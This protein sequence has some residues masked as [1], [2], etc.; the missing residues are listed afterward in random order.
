MPA[1]PPFKKNEVRDLYARGTWAYAL[2]RPA[3]EHAQYAEAIERAQYGKRRFNPWWIRNFGDVEATLAGCW[4]DEKAGRDVV[5]FCAIL[6][7]FE[8]DFAGKPFALSDWQTYDIV[9]PVFGW[10]QVNGTR[11]F[12]RVHN[13][14]PKKNGKTSLAAALIL[15]FLIGDNEP[16]AEIFTAAVDR[17]QSGKMFRSVVQM[18]R[19]SPAILK[20]VDI[21]ESRYRVVCQSTA[22]FYEALSGEVIDM[23]GANIYA[24]LKDEAHVWP[25]DAMHEVTK[26]GGA[27]RKQP[28]D[29]LIST[30]GKFD[31]TSYGYN[32]YDF[33][34]KYLNAIGGA[35]KINEFFGYICGLTKDE[36]DF[37]REPAMCV[38]ANPNIDISI[39]LEADQKMCDEAMVKQREIPG[40]KRYRRNI[41]VNALDAWIPQDKW[42]ARREDYTWDDLKDL[43][44]YAGLDL[45]LSDD[46]TALDLCFPPQGELDTYRFWS[47]YWC[48]EGVIEKRDE[49]YNGWYSM[50]AKDGY[51]LTTPGETIKQEFVHEK[52]REVREAVALR[53]IGYDRA[54][55]AKLAQDLETDG[56]DVGAFGQGFPAMNEPTKLLYD[57]VMDGRMQHPGHPI[58]DWHVSNALAIRDGGDR[59]RIVKNWGAG[60]G[61]AKVR[62]KVD[63]VIAR[64]QS[65]GT[66]QLDPIGVFDAAELIR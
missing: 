22:S 61:K 60:P 38:K 64:I 10:K 9:I 56:F 49:Q 31:P 5:D 14:V 15:Y 65:L 16:A 42:N 54:F 1:N 34:Q 23:E 52:L 47:W 12:R 6:R 24:M 37:W 7:H 36:E 27:A 44:C 2:G 39:S 57:L 19:K 51:L 58:M 43:T 8:G 46:I 28:I 66:A 4:M 45:S 20:R 17:K 40:I 63:A 26:H 48:P 32:E 25:S 55:A 59:I 33:C 29:W 50:W 35:E 3:C 62:Y 21:V 30:S 41:W 11:R 18:A 53:T 13:W